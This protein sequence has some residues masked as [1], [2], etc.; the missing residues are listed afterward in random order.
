MTAF[1]SAIPVAWA[2]PSDL[3]V[4]ACAVGAVVSALVEALPIPINDNVR[5]PLVAGLAMAL[6]GGTL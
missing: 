6:V 4:A 1:L 3:P 5:V 2:A